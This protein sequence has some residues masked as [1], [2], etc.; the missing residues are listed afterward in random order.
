MKNKKYIIIFLIF[1]LLISVWTFSYLKIFKQ[2]NIKNTEF[3][4]ELKNNEEVEKTEVK[5]RTFIWFVRTDCPNCQSEMPVLQKFYDKY[6]KFAN[7]RLIVIDWKSMWEEYTI[8]QDFD[9][10]VSYTDL[11]GETCDYVPSYVI[12]DEDKN[13][14]TKACGQAVEYDTL[15]NYLIKTNNTLTNNLEKP[16]TEIFQTKPL[17]EWDLAVVLTTTNGKME[18]KMFNKEVP[19]T[20][21]N[22]MALAQKG[23]YNGITFHRVINNF[24]IQWG[25]PTATWAGW[26]SIY[27]QAFEDEFN[28]NLK[29]IRGSLSMANSWANTNGSQ[30]FI[31]QVN[32]NYLDNKHSVFGQVVTGLDNVDKIA[33]TKVWAN[34]KPVKD[35]KII[36]AEVMQYDGMKLVPYTLDIE[37]KMA[38]F[39]AEEL[40]KQEANKSRIVKNSDNIAV[41]YKLTLEDGT[42]KDSSYD[43]GEPIVFTVWAGQMIPGFD[44]AVVGMKIGDKKTIT[45][46]PSEAYG[47]Y[48]ESKTQEMPREQLASFEQAGIILEAG[49]KLPTQMWVFT[50]KDVTEETVVIDLNP[51]LAGKT[52]TFD[53]E[54]VEFKN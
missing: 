4:Q 12:L 20:A 30:F 5:L 26:E 31:N 27:G 29:N 48:D 50:V 51:E 43:R 34:D 35:I 14:L 47:E 46:E 9:Y 3:S 36:K 49:A 16:M 52:L 7:M 39:E 33:K 40:A 13:I 44:K 15:E 21:F 18:I 32:N 22:F 37:A 11:T 1:A 19:K 38:E 23:Y 28:D 45:L 6:N 24:M 17:E 41:H 53:I 2:E 42:V 25:D 54:M 8:P 10:P